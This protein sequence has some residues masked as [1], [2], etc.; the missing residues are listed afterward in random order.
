MFKSQQK[1][2]PADIGASRD[3][4][5]TTRHPYSVS[6]APNRAPVTLKVPKTA[7]LGIVGVIVLGIAFFGGV[8]YGHHSD[9]TKNNASTNKSTT[10]GANNGNF[11]GD[12]GYGDRGHGRMG[13]IGQ[14]TAVNGDQFTVTRN[15]GSTTTVQT[16]SSTTYE[17][18]TSVSTGDTV[19]VQGT[20]NS[21]GVVQATRVII[22]P[23]FGGFSGGDNPDSTNGNSSVN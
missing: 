1:H 13:T 16:S 19:V 11:G 2:N 7:L 9:D 21:S 8:A 15:D 17:N 6:S 4:E 12:G 20:A 5:D 14:V 22:N 23:T 3:A 10:T 18:G